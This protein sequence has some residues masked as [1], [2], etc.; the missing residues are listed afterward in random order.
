MWGCGHGDL[1]KVY[2]ALP[3]LTG[4]SGKPVELVICCGDFEALRNEEDLA[5]MECPTKYKMMH[6]FWEYYTGVKKAP[7]LTLF[8]GGNHEPMNHMQELAYGGWVAPNI[9][10]LGSSGVLW[11]R[12]LRIAGMSGI[13]NERNYSKDRKS[14]V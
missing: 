1:D 7:V 8:I 9:F 11:F 4:P 3:I 2:T 10:Y 5:C 13:Y 14:V 6:N 12:G